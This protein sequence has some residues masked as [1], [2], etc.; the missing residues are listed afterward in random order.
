MNSL[1]RLSRIN[2]QDQPLEGLIEVFRL[3]SLVR[4]FKPMP[5]HNKERSKVFDQGE[6]GFEERMGGTR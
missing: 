1:L 3:V 5:V 4:L 2:A 6:Q